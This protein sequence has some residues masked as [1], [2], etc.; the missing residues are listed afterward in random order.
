MY[1]KDPAQTSYRLLNDFISKQINPNPVAP[2]QTISQPAV[3]PPPATATDPQL[4]AS[5]DPTTLIP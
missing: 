1:A 5:E 3:L 2:P 4:P